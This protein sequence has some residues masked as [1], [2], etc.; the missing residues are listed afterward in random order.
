MGVIE[1]LID[2]LPMGMWIA[3]AVVITYLIAHMISLYLHKGPQEK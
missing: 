1:K 3:F 2:R